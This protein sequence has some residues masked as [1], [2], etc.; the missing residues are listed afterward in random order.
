MKKI[1]LT[2]RWPAEVEQAL[3]THYECEFNEKDEPFS[4]SRLQQ[5]LVNADALLTTVTDRL[6]ATTLGVA[7]TRAKIIAN[8]GVGYSHIDTDAARDAGI[9]V[10][11][12]PDV[13]SDCTADL[14]LTLLLMAAR[15]AS[16]GER[17]LRAGLWSGWR[18]THLMGTKVSGK[19][20][21]IIGFGRIGRAMAHKAHHGF[22]MDIVVY[23]RST[24]A[25]N[26]LNTVNARQLTS[27][28]QLLTCADF[29][30]LHCPGGQENTHLL[31]AERIAMMKPQSYLI[32]TARG[33]VIDESA[34]IDA[35]ASQRIAGAGLDVFNNEPDIDQRFLALD[36]A[37]LLP[38]LGSATVETRQDM[39][40]RVLSNLNQYFSGQQ[41]DD[42]VC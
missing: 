20:L 18:P 14:A 3:A 11:N 21:G 38:H 26:A 10:T 22:G 35:L 2:R 25:D 40:L 9:A 42:Q 24:V 41:P 23:N 30:S 36:N 37:V 12:T 13:L 29:V 6:D 5:A 8:F 17:E 34:L 39:G 1:I 4:Q 27:I 31:N 15:R 32:N 19:T 16:E 33:E 7:D 28:E